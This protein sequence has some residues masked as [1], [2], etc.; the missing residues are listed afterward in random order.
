MVKVLK[1]RKEKE[2]EK[3]EIMSTSAYAWDRQ[4]SETVAN[5]KLFC[6]YR[7][8]GHTRTIMKVSDLNTGVIYNTVLGLDKKFQWKK[9]ALAYDEFR[10]F[11]MMTKLE[12]EILE[13]RMRQQIL[14]AEMQ[15]LG[16]K[17]V[18]LLN[19]GVENLSPAD[20]TK[21]IDIG[22]KIENLSL[23]KST[24]IS[25]SKVHGKVEIA[26]E[27]IDPSIAA[28]LGKLIAIKKSE[29]MDISV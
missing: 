18:K 25:E 20:I 11:E 24:E 28:E 9:R 8:M 16:A 19:E 6:L 5:F 13:S 12:E 7:N 2:K 17:G 21:L 29:K 26:V 3:A 14:G 4:I 10:D 27:E 22:T 1:S 15:K 23:G